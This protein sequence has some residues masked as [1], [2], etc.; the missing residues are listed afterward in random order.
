VSSVEQFARFLCRVLHFSMWAD[1]STYRAGEHAG[2]FAVR[3]R[4]CKRRYE[5][6]KVIYARAPVGKTPSE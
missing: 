4:I 3:C 1:V 6:R 2:P 5:F